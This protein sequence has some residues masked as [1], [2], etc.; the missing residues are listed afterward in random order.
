MRIFAVDLRIVGMSLEIAKVEKIAE[1]C[2][3]VPD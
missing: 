2:K 3:L 1:V